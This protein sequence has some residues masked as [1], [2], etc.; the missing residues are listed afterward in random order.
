MNLLIL[1]E[2]NNSMK[3][4]WSRME[5]EAQLFSEYDKIIDI[6]PF[7]SVNELQ[8]KSSS[9]FQLP[10]WLQSDRRLV[11]AQRERLASKN[12]RHFWHRNEI[13]H[14]YKR[15]NTFDAQK[16]IKRGLIICN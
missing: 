3:A 11:G 15:I 9:T 7:W 16:G 10:R 13:E 14:H 8:A 2:R 1:H 4:C 12:T 6:T 5:T